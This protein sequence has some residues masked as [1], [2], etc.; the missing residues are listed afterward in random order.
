MYRLKNIIAGF[1]QQGGFLLVDSIAAVV[2]LA[3]GLTAVGTLYMY[4]T[5]YRMRASNRQKAVQIAAERIERLK[6]DEAIENGTSLDDLQTTVNK[7]N[8]DEVVLTDNETFKVK[9][10]D[11]VSLED[12]TNLSADAG[13]AIVETTVTWPK[14][15]NDHS[16]TLYSYIR[17]N[18]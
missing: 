18:D 2:I 10:S 14:D 6:V 11:P 8:D 9:M 15:K 17:T 7:I 13:L 4:G 16:I 5:D 3:I 1:K 12:K